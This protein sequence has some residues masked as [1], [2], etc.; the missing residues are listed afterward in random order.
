MVLNA[1]LSIYTLIVRK[2]FK[3]AVLKD[4]RNGTWRVQ[5]TFK[6]AFGNSIRKQRRGFK[7]KKEAQKWER[8]FLN[9]FEHSVDI[10]FGNLTKEY[11]KD[12]EKRNRETTI[13]IKE[14]IV[15][16]HILPYFENLPINEIKPLT[17]RSWHTALLEQDFS[18]TY[19][20][21]ISAQFNLIMNFACKY[22][23]LQKNPGAVT[24]TIGT[25]K[26][27][28]YK[29]WTLEDYKK[30]RSVLTKERDI[31]AM[32][33]FYYSGMRRGELLALTLED[34]DT[35][36]NTISIN[37]NMVFVSTG[38]RLHKPKTR[39]SERIIHM[40]SF[41]I[42]EVIEYSK[43]I[44]GL[45]S[46]DYIF[47]LGANGAKRIID[48]NYKKAGVERIRVHDL[49]HSHVSLLINLGVNVTTIA[50]RLGH[51]NIETTWNTY[52]HL[53][54]TKRQEVA[55]LLDKIK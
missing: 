29:F 18:K 12:I 55:Q 42:K 14:T 2:E 38:P 23:G 51:E 36:N 27:D 9:S 32:D 50:D 10:T 49:R 54:P 52:S 41:V 48:T 5:T 24:G 11:F 22:Y 15:N 25:Q 17:V 3:M 43:K 4:K 39:K 34:I 35:E 31:V 21:A 16:Q 40:P 1:L 20:K 13:E 46:T 19:L 45:E 30:F 7:T 26:K 6:D 8:D 47:D 53:Y 44:Y 28:E 37:K 33:L